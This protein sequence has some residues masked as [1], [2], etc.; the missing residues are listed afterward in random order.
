LTFKKKPT[1][2]V[3]PLKSLLRQKDTPKKAI[4]VDLSSPPPLEPK[5]VFLYYI[6]IWKARVEEVDIASASAQRIVSGEFLRKV[7]SWINEVKANQANRSFEDKYSIRATASYNCI[8][9]R[10]MVP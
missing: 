2:S 1:K 3:K 9:A 4:T 8:V 7:N 10:D 6:A 5:V